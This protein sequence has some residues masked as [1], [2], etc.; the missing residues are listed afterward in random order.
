MKQSLKRLFSFPVLIVGFAFALRM[1]VMCVLWRRAPTPIKANPPFGLELVRVAR[2]IA[3]GEGF[4]SPLHDM[5]T[6][7]TAWF[8]PIYPY[9]LAGIFKLWGRRRTRRLVGLGVSPDGPILS[10]RMDMGYGPYGPHFHANFLG[11]TGLARDSNDSTMGRLRSVVGS[12]RVDQSLDPF[13]ISVFPGMAR[14]ERTEGSRPL[15]KARSGG[16]FIVY[17]WPG[18]MDYP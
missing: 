9:L 8:T 4:S 3:A 6:G 11:D 18:P 10:R 5:D 7:P 17:D 2:A 1:I 15:G 16:P 13:P 14:L 12:R